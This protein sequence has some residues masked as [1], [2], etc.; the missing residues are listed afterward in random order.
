LAQK[1]IC[2]K[3]VKS[4]VFFCGNKRLNTLPDKLLSAQIKLD[5]IVVYETVD[6]AQKV[7]KVYDGILFF[8][9]SA[10]QSFFSLNTLHP[11]TVI[12]SIGDTTTNEIKKFTKVAIISCNIPS[13]EQMMELV[14][15]HFA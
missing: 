6:V 12:F 10:V 3:S 8:S 5:E 14:I 2:N 13:Q 1:I 7:E 4:C 9:P 11:Q 15:K